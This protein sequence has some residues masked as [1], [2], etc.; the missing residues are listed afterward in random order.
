MEGIIIKTDVRF[1]DDEW[2]HI[3]GTLETDTIH[4]AKVPAVR[5][6]FIEKAQNKGADF[7][8]GY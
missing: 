6:E 8:F 2:V 7:I 5:V 1:S 3:K 4:S